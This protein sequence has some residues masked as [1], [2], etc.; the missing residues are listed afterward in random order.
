MLLLYHLHLQGDSSSTKF[1]EDT[2]MGNIPFLWLYFASIISLIYIK[3]NDL[4]FF[5]FLFRVLGF[6]EFHF[7]MNLSDRKNSEL[8]YLLR[9]LGSS[10]VFNSNKRNWNF[11]SF[12][13]FSCKLQVPFPISS[14][15]Y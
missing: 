5:F 6:L 10:H 11:L 2:E 9:L 7:H 14:S 1:W 4:F 13:V 12:C 3:N 8:K 15:L